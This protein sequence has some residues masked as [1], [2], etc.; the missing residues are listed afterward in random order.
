[1]NKNKQKT[2][3][4]TPIKEAPFKSGLSP[5]QEKAAIM[6]ANGDSVTLVAES[7]NVN[8]TTIYQ[9]Q[10]KVTFQCF[11]NIQKKEATQNLWNGLTA[12]YQDALQAVKDVLRSDNDAMKL[13]AA[14]L[15]IAKVESSPVGATDA[16]AV[17][18]KQ[19]TEIKDPLNNDELFKPIQILDN[20][21]YQQLLAEN[22]LED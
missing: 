17:L 9:W 2:T 10:Q 15:I 3:E 22:G 21:Q 5:I 18:R 6:L 16:K 20:S 11:F 13:K 7:L 4:S 12:L 8:R 14:M 1:M 19:A